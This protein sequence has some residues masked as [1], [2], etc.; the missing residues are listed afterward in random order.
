MQSLRDESG[1]SLIE[2]LF[3]C[4]ITV[5]LMAALAMVFS[6]GLQTGS[7]TSGVAASQTGVTVAFDRLDYEVRCASR[8]TLL[9]SGAGV[10]LTLPSQCSHAT[11]TTTWCVSSG[12][13]MR[14]SGASCSGS[15]Q[16]LITGVSSTAP[17]SCVAPVGVYPGVKVTLTVNNGRAT[18]EAFAGTDVITLKNAPLTTSTTTACS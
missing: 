11:G 1:F 4:V 3:V 10:T 9:S 8:A 6:I 13:L 16:T 12:S 17:F 14:Y 2:V 5:I 7:T 18:Q 15:G